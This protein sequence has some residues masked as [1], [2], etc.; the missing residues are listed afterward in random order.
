M[1]PFMTKTQTN[2]SQ[3]KKPGEVEDVTPLG[4]LNERGS[5]TDKQV[6][7]A[8]APPAPAR[9]GERCHQA[10]LAAGGPV[11]TAGRE[12]TAGL[13]S[14]RCRGSAARR[15]THQALGAG[16]RTGRCRAPLNLA[17]P[18]LSLHPLRVQLNKRIRASPWR[19]PDSI[20][21]T[22]SGPA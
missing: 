18:Q 15:A 9:R 3:C 8:P 5:S 2:K 14:S 4:L 17:V 1:P 13:R 11:A 12:P 7:L 21:T 19:A 10:P 6:G 16:T 20:L 22:E